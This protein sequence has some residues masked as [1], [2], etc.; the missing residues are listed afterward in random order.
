M[1]R[2]SKDHSRTPLGQT[3]STRVPRSSLTPGGLRFTLVSGGTPQVNSD[4]A[5]QE[6]QSVALTPT[7]VSSS[8]SGVK[9][10]ISPFINNIQNLM[11]LF[12]DG[13]INHKR[14]DRRI[15]R[16]ARKRYPEPSDLA[17]L[18]GMADPSEVSCQ[19]QQFQST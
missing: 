12:L 16:L 15:R 13:K 17:Q 10:A 14:I 8:L 1:K 3:K 18:D 4:I 5:R 7:S 9:S 2:L 11:S 6:R 19:I